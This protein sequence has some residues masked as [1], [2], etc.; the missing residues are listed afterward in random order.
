M[1]DDEHTSEPPQTVPGAPTVRK[2]RRPAR[3]G[4]GAAG[5]AG[6]LAGAAATARPAP[7]LAPWAVAWRTESAVEA[8]RIC[9][10]LAEAG[11]RSSTSVELK[12]HA[13]MSTTEF[14]AVHVPEPDVDL[15]IARIEAHPDL[16]PGATSYSEPLRYSRG[17]WGR[18]RHAGPAAKVGY[19]CFVAVMGACALGIVLVLVGTL[20]ASA[21]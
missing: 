20:I 5:G 16:F 21:T 1:A 4:E 15:A 18:V 9:D 3:T 19:G 6:G 12:R 11:I 13:A 17:M 14:V 7:A 2:T 10:H 8:A